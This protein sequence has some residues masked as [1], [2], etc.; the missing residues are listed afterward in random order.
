MKVSVCIPSYNLARF[1][2]EAIA[3]VLSQSLGD[4]ELLIEDD[5]S[6][7]DSIEAIRAFKDERIT[8]FCKAANDGAN[9]TTNNLVKRA[10]GE[11]I[12]LLAADDVWQRDK[13]SKQVA[14]LDSHPRCG[15]VFGWPLFIN[16]AGGFLHGAPDV[17]YCANRSRMAWR[18]LFKRR[19]ILFVSTS[20]YR[21]T[22]HKELGYF[23]NEFSVLADMEWY[24]RILSKYDL[25]VLQEPLASFRVRENQANL[26]APTPRTVR[27]QNEDIEEII[28]RHYGVDAPQYGAVL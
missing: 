19:N 24:L 28:R 5:G 16:E 12:A 23:A 9:A 6:T 25:H 27:L 2:G 20:L 26:S 1:V 22:L 8:L 4:F 7:D 15:I 11:Y 17:A 18:S 14:Y 13:L 10:R 3:S 21:A